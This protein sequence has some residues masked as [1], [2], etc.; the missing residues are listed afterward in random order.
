MADWHLTCE[1]CGGKTFKEEVLEIKFKQK[2]IYDVLNLTVDEAIEF[3]H[4]NYDKSEFDA[5]SAMFEDDSEIETVWKQQHKLQDLLDTS[6]FK[7]YSELKEKLYRVLALDDAG[8]TAPSAYDDEDDGIA[9]DTSMPS[10]S[11][12]PSPTMMDDIPFDTAPS[13]VNVDDDD[14]D[15]SIFKELAKG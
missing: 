7:S 3:F 6:N 13:S 5:P 8:P 12:A 15:L 1:D 14:D 2:S 9:L 11:P 10:S 4:R